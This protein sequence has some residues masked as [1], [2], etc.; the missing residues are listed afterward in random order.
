ML[1]SLACRQQAEARQSTWLICSHAVTQQGA[2]AAARGCRLLASWP[3]GTAMPHDALGAAHPSPSTI[4]HCP[5]C[6]HTT[7]LGLLSW[8]TRVWEMCCTAGRSKPHGITLVPSMER[9]L[10][11]IWI[12]VGCWLAGQSHK[13]TSTTAGM[14][15]RS[16]SLGTPPPAGVA[17]TERAL[18]SGPQPRVFP[19]TW[20]TLLGG[21]SVHPSKPHLRQRLAS[22]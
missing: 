6:P 10:L 9:G 17:T 5:F 18:C 15:N 11:F 2:R 20:D 4:C 21:H 12:S 8:D 13:H 22:F 3:P 19:R 1:L 14:A 16:G 7:A